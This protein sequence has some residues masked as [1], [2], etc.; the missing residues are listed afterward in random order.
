MPIKNA[1]NK[2][3]EYMAFDKGDLQEKF[4]K[5]ADLAS[6]VLDE[7][8]DLPNGNADERAV[9]KRAKDDATEQLLREMVGDMTDVDNSAGRIKL[10]LAIAGEKS[11]QIRDQKARRE[12]HASD[13][14][15]FI[16][17]MHRLDQLN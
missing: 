2:G 11:A 14:L 10:A 13:A 1:C 3:Y 15:T 5:G 8:K 17:L 4:V 9:H 12:K 7:D 16:L 6:L